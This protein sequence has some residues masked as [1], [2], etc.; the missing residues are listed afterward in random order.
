MGMKKALRLV[1]LA[2]TLS[3][4][5]LGSCDLFSPGLGDDVDI[6]PPVI[7]ITDPVSDPLQ[8]K[9]S[10]FTVSGTVSDDVAAKKVRLSW[11]GGGTDASIDGETWSADVNLG[12]ISS[13]GTILLSAV[14]YD[15]AGKAQQPL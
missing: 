2:A 6:T 3:I 8:Y 10:S 13:R 12:E 5:N 7:A 14:A 15:N 1:S 11:P 9:S 4:L